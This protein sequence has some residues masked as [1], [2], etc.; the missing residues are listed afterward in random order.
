MGRG[1]TG[2]GKPRPP[3]VLEHDVER[4][5]GNLTIIVS[6]LDRRRHELTDWRLQLKRHALAI[7]LAA[8]G[9]ALV[10][11]G[12]I[13]LFIAKRRRGSS[14]RRRLRREEG[15]LGKRLLSAI[16]GAVVGALAKRF[17]NK[18]LLPPARPR[19]RLQSERRVEPVT[20]H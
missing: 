7:G 4:L 2:V 10:V 15:G 17:A 18:L 19:R 6:E 3:E 13:A 20:V 5:R 9:L 14:R 8:G 16:A 11:G 1:T 12:S